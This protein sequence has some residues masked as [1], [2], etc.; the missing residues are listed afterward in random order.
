MNPP[1]ESWETAGWVS[2]TVPART[3]TSAPLVGAPSAPNTRKRMSP[4][5]SWKAITTFPSF[6]VAASGALCTP[7]VV[8]FTT[9][10]AAVS[11]VLSGR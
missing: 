11:G 10:S 5:P 1:S 8:L 7:A 3:S 2:V 9:M 6:S 4:P